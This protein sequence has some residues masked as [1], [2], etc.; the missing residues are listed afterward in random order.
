M[1]IAGDEMSESESDKQ[2]ANGAKSSAS[3]YE[4]MLQEVEE[5]VRGHI[6]FQQQ[7]KLHIESVEARL[8]IA[9]RENEQ[10]ASQNLELINALKEKLERPATDQVASDVEELAELRSQVQKTLD[11]MQ[12]YK[13]LHSETMQSLQDSYSADL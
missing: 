10:L 7:L 3:C 4:K 12:E 5:D 1:L 9:D 11:E 2:S 6:R 13:R 8:E